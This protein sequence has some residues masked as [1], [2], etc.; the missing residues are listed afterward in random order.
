MM[1]YRYNTLDWKLIIAVIVI[2]AIV[3]VMMVNQ[4]SLIEFSGPKEISMDILPNET[5]IFNATIKSQPGATP[6]SNYTWEA[7][8]RNIF[9]VEEISKNFDGY[10]SRFPLESGETRKLKFRLTLVGEDPPEGRYFIDFSLRGPV[11]GRTRRISN[12]YRLWVVLES[13]EES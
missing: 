6:Y 3:L 8:G 2:V 10:Q 4:S 5:V 13:K 7:D 1:R 12:T 11:K 9:V